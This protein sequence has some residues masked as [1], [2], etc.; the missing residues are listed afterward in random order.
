MSHTCN[1]RV[2]NCRVQAPLLTLRPTA[3]NVLTVQLGYACVREVCVRYACAAWVLR[4][5]L[6][7][8]CHQTRQG[9]L[10]TLRPTAP[11]VLRASPLIGATASSLELL[12]NGG[13]FPQLRHREGGAHPLL[14]CY[15]LPPGS[16]N[17]RESEIPP[18]GCIHTQWTMR[19]RA[20]RSAV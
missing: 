1:T 6:P 4:I 17:A 5:Q 18:K 3:P 7:P 9:P 13:C 2:F 8:I 20:A 11:K 19:T 14:F 15:A 10:M 12:T 16:L